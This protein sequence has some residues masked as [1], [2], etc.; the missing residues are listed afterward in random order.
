MLLR[1]NEWAVLVK[2]CYQGNVQLSYAWGQKVI[3][4]IN[5]VSNLQPKG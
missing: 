4:L 3:P 5:L 2:P 1:V